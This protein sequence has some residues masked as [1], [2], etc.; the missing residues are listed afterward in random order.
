M[1]E[2]TEQ[3]LFFKYLVICIRNLCYCLFIWVGKHLYLP[4]YSASIKTVI[5]GQECWHV[6][7]FTLVGGLGR[8]VES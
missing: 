7:T 6:L 2:D 4:F 8:R 1:G 5:D 3:K